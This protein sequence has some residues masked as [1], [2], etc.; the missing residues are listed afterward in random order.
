MLSNN[1]NN[2]N[3]NKNTLFILV[4]AVNKNH[5]ILVQMAHIKFPYLSCSAFV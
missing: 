2:K 1:S 5:Y 3:N 4:Q